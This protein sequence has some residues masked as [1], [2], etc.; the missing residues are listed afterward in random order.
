MSRRTSGAAADGAWWSG[1]RCVGGKTAVQVGHQDLRVVGGVEGHSPPV[2]RTLVYD[3][4]T[5]T[6]TGAGLRHPATHAVVV[7]LPDGRILVAGGMDDCE[8][9]RSC[10]LFDP[11]V[12]TWTAA[13]PMCQPPVWGRGRARRTRACRRR[14]GRAGAANHTME[15]YDRRR[16]EFFASALQAFLRRGCAAST[17][18]GKNLFSLQGGRRLQLLQGR[19]RGAD[20]ARRVDKSEVLMRSL[21]HFQ[22]WADAG[23]YY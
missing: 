9:L 10:E 12:G 7:A 8:P 13:A 4:W 20:R 1:P 2:K 21:G 14:Q 22:H 18:G 3:V 6:W 5:A 19:S 11:K 17:I 16:W 15:R 23:T